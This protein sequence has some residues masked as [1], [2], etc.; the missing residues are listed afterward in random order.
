M[1]TN[2]KK[3]NK[4]G[5]LSLMRRETTGKGESSIFRAGF[6]LV[7]LLVT[8]TMFVIITGVVLINS[9][10]FDNTVLLHNF[11]YDVALTIKQAQIYGVNTLESGSGLF[12]TQLQGYGVYFDRSIPNGNTHFV[13]FNDTNS[14]KKYPDVTTCLTDSECIQKYSMTKG[15]FIQS[16]CVVG[17]S[18]GNCNE[19]NQL[20]ILFI[21]PNPEALI[22]VNNGQSIQSPSPQYAKI[23]LSS[24]GG[25]TSSVVVTSV[26]QIYVK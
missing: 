1:E 4:N 12:N 6:T 19:V 10:T 24:A 25:A 23:I 7:E 21:R 13:L 22:F 26:G 11:V 5:G 14:D 3:L 20:S 2:N 8:I 17:N 9:N 18:G 16:I 15:T